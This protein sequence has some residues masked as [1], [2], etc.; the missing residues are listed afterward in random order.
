[1]EQLESFPSDGGIWTGPKVARG[2]EQETGRKKVW[3]QRGWDYLKKCE[4]SWQ[5]PRSTHR[6]GDKL[7]QEIFKA[8]LPLKVKELEKEYPKTEIELW[9]LGARREGTFLFVG[10]DS[11]VDS[12]CS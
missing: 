7:E 10:F 6:K 1:M 12:A 11:P 9:F 8:N 2:I 4:Y 3:N 5:K